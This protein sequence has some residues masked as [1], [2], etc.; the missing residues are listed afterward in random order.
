[1]AIGNTDHEKTKSYNIIN[2]KKMTEDHIKRIFD[3]SVKIILKSKKISPDIKNAS[4]LI[5]NCYNNG[6]K[7]IAFGNGGSAADAQHIAAE[8]IGRFKKERDSFPA[9]AL[10]TDSSVITSIGNDYSFEKIFSRQCESL[11]SKGDVVIGITTSGESKNVIQGLKIAKNLG[12]F[13]IGILGNSNKK[14]KSHLDI[15]INV[16]STNTARIQ[17]VHRLI[18]HIICEIVENRLSAHRKHNKS[19]LFIKSASQ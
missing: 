19:K 3:D 1:V 14:I 5:I 13:T 11:V 16:S 17:E 15:S 8:L 18:Y 4:E 12:A 6:G 7:V 2:L 10:T 9:I